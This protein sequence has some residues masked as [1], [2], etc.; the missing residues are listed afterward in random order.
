[1]HWKW[2]QRITRLLGQ[3][4]ESTEY[5]EIRNALIILTKIS[6]VFPVTKKS[7]MNLERRVRTVSSSNF[8]WVLIALASFCYCSSPYACR[9]PRSRVMRERTSRCWQQVLV[10]PWLLERF[11]VPFGGIFFNIGMTKKPYWSCQKPTT[12]P[13]A[14]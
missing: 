2:S 9:C 12:S 13:L 3:C 8:L 10:L 1:M 5:M 4:L 7:G 14:P 6:S 11:A